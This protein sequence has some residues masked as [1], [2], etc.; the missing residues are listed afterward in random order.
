MMTSTS[1]RHFLGNCGAV[2]AAALLPVSTVAAAPR[3]QFAYT[4]MTW[5]N[6][7]AQAIDDIAALGFQGIQF[8]DSVVKNFTPAQLRALLQQRR[9]TFT[10]LSSG[11]VALDADPKDEIARHVANARYLKDSGG[12]YLQVLDKLTTYPRAPVAA[13]CAQLGRLLTEI[14]RRTADLGIT[15]GYHNHLNTLSQT[16]E[17]LERILA[18]ADARYVKFELDTA[19]AVAGGGDPAKMIADYRQQLLF[20]HLK[21]VVD[22]PADAKGKYP[23]QFV[24][25]GRGRVDFDGVFAALDKIDFHG[26]AVI[27]L[28]RV[29]QPGVTPRQSAMISKAYLK[30]ELGVQW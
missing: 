5:G 30:Q 28:D 17:G 21:D 20:L 12:L 4:A 14:G 6:E 16:P 29:P 27:E 24:E 11:T 9:L 23:F 1:R 7:E 19:H 8:R 25:L 10:A 22:V 15:L 13:D 18:A 2:A 3:M 26:W